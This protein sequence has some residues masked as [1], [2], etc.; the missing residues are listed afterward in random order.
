MNPKALSRETGYSVNVRRAERA[1]ASRCDSPAHALSLI[2]VRALA[3]LICKLVWFHIA[4]IN[5]V[6][7]RLLTVVEHTHKYAPMNTLALI[8]CVSSG[9]N[10]P[11]FALK[12]SEQS[13][14]GRYILYFSLWVR[15]LMSFN[16][17]GHGPRWVN[18]KKSTVAYFDLKCSWTIALYFLWCST[19][20]PRRN[21]IALCV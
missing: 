17:F 20:M 9:E 6:W 15:V 2:A 19:H 13:K 11:Q 21:P 1:R 3:G 4:A 14:G 16:E 5:N 7:A 10:P 8:N 12:A 18:P